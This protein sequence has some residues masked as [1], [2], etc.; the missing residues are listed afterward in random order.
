MNELPIYPYVRPPEMEGIYRTP[1]PVAIVGAGLTGL[2]LALDLVQR[3]IPV[4]VLDDDNTVGV[5]G[6]ASRGMVWAQR[7]LDIFER[8]GVAS[9]VVAKGVRWNVGRVLCRDLAV[10]S[11]RCKTSLTCDTTVS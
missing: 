10:A 3:G 4:V 6:L 5:R 8:L 9:N 2:T 11:S 1:Y 7:T